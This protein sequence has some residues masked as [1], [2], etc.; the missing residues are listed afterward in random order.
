MSKPRWG[1]IGLGVGLQ[2]AR[3]LAQLAEVELVALCDRDPQALAQAC[4]EF[5]GVSAHIQEN[6][7]LDS[8]EVD[9]VVI[10]TYDN[11][12]AAAIIRA[13]GNGLHVFAEKP[14]ATSRT[15]LA[16]IRA[17]LDRYPAVRLSTN[18]LLRRSP[19][20]AWLKSRIAAGDLGE[21]FHIEGD[22]LYGRLAKLTEGWRGSDSDY[23]VTLGGAIHIVDLLMWLAGE[24]P[25]R[26]SAIG[27]SKGLRDSALFGSSHF[28]GDDFRVALLEFDSGLTAKVSANFACV[29]PHFHRVDVFGS[30]A[31]FLHV[32]GVG[33]TGSEASKALLFTSRDPASPP[34]VVDLPYPAV[35]KGALL[36]EFNRVVFGTGVP[37]IPEQE[38]L[39]VMAVC[40]AID[41]SRSKGYAVEVTYEQVTPRHARLDE[42]GEVQ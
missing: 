31:T 20:F 28:L 7:L 40:L 2:H 13:I 38:V 30:D 42:A 6:D 21:L 36:P 3:E 24:R 29:L 37:D 8:G 12:H 22:Y 39:D 15:E 18:T 14:L 41:E 4:A 17:E 33:G 32:P 25:V 27:S 35:Q 34:T 11:E 9:A 23:S 19:R 10:A 5:P 16:A 26:V 1:V